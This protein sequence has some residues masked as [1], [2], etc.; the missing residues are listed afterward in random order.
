MLHQ[1]ASPSLSISVTTLPSPSPT[2][3]H[4]SLIPFFPPTSLLLIF[5]A[6]LLLPSIS[7]HA[8]YPL[9]TS[10]L[11]LEAKSLGLCATTHPTRSAH[12]QLDYS[13]KSNI[14]SQMACSHLTYWHLYQ[15]QV[16]EVQLS[17]ALYCN[18]L[19]CITA[20]HC[21]ALQCTGLQ[22]STVFRP[23]SLLRN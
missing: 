4:I 15:D 9:R 1:P 6:S 14:P 23:S 20:L 3:N 11:F 17:T 22:V 18:I 2:S 16:T 7:P 5:M 13:K 8:N 19:H 10:V 21:I 12:S